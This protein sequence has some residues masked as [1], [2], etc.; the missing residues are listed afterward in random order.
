MIKY[1]ILKMKN[2]NILKTNY[3]YLNKK[4]SHTSSKYKFPIVY[5]NS[6]LNKG[7]VLK[8]N[9]NKSGIYRLVNKIN[10]ESYVGSS[11]NLTN[12]FRRYYNINYLKGKILKDNSR[13][14]RALLK[15]NYSNF[16]LEIL[17]Y[18][19]N[20]SLRSREQYYL[21]SLMP[22]YNIC[23]TAGSMLGFKHSLET[24]EKFKNRDLGTGHF[25]IVINKESNSIIKYNSIRAAAKDLGISHTTLLHHINKNSTVKG[26]YIII[27]CKIKYK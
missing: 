12:R 14:Y 17:E 6:L 16:N 10:G 19:S 15:Y 23:K 21:D 5:E 2:N 26:I 1:N 20:E 7:K 18:C 3:L 11:I 13:I 25:T 27:R 9:K 22:E 4:Y 8:E 24:L